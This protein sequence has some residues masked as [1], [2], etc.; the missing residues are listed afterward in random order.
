MNNTIRE[1]EINESILVTYH[2]LNSLYQNFFPQYPK[3]VEKEVVDLIN[4]L[5]EI[6]EP[7]DDKRNC[8]IKDSVLFERITYDDNN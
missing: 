2:V 6:L 1:Y 5:M 3:D 4:H 8:D 7:N